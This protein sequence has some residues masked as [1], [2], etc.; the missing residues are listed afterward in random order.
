MVKAKT[1][2]KTAAK[3][4][5]WKSLKHARGPATRVPAQ[6]EQLVSGGPPSQGESPYWVLRDTLVGSG[7]WYDASAPAVALLLDSVAKAK[8]PAP[9]FMIAADILGGDQVRGW[10]APP[11]APADDNERAAHEAAIERK[12]ILLG[13]LASS[14][15]V[16]RG[17]A[18]M[19]LAMIPGL[20]AESVPALAKAAAEDADAF[21]RAG[22]LLALGRLGI[23]DATSAKV[24]DAARGAK[25]SSLVRGAAGMAWLRHDEKRPFDQA[26]EE[27]SGWLGAAPPEGGE[28]PWFKAPQRYATLGFPDAPARAL[29][30]LGLSRGKSG[31]DALG[32]AVVALAATESGVVEAQLAKIMLDLGGFPAE[33]TPTVALVEE[34]SAEQKAIAAKL[35]ATHLLPAGG[36]GLPASGAVRRRWMGID[37]PGPLDRRVESAGAPAV[38]LW[39]AWQKRTPD[40]GDFSSPLDRW[41]ALVEYGSASYPP[42]FRAPKLDDVPAEL[43]ALPTGADTIDRATRVL[44]DL[45]ARF[46]AIGRTGMNVP[47]YL[48]VSMLL[49]TPV[50]RAGH[51]LPE[52]WTVLFHIGTEPQSR[53]MFQAL[54]PEARERALVAYLRGANPATMWGQGSVG[55]ALLDLSPT[56]KVVDAIRWLIAELAKNPFQQQGVTHLT[57]GLEQALAQ[58]PKLAS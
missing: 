47:L 3:P 53:E 19:A 41:E 36:H 20:A 27:L 5:A 43:S 32:S 51:A 46:A 14:T 54:S 34:L 18:A 57:S 7:A 12:A 6:V 25:T 29:S 9:L 23:G 33:A 10:L 31:V 48:N 42:F 28:L 16:V 44:D 38:P 1:P 15:G 58:H 2:S 26:K 30:G 45:A 52:A 35:A 21:G 17:A 40:S 37:P 8:D 55:L 4:A 50:L 39:R 13:G 22:A 24:I 56:R 11:A 49:L